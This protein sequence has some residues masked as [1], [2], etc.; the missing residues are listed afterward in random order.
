[1]SVAVLLDFPDGSV[2]AYDRVIARMGLSGGEPPPGAIFHVA[3]ARPE[4]GFRVVDVW[5]SG[6]AFQAFADAQIGPIT[7]AEG[8]SPPTVSMWPVHNTMGAAVRR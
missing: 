2:E 5:E 7:A 6:E 1:M 8:F 3:G 4:G